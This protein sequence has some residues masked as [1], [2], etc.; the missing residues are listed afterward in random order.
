M[1]CPNNLSFYALLDLR[2]VFQTLPLSLCSVPHC[3][4]LKQQLQC[5][6][7]VCVL[8]CARLKTEYHRRDYS[9]LLPPPT[10]SLWVLHGVGDASGSQELQKAENRW[11]HMQ[12]S[13]RQGDWRQERERE[14]RDCGKGLGL[15]IGLAEA[16]RQSLNK[17][18]EKERYI[19]RGESSRARTPQESSPAFSRLP[20]GERSSNPSHFHPSPSHSPLLWEMTTNFPPFSSE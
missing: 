15:E 20:A 12:T 10:D 9:T 13:G 7:S 19:G 14:G 11:E 3:P 6:T 1:L 8:V 16:L 17:A 5:M 4:F 18:G 2:K